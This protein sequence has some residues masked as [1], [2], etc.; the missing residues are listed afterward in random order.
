MVRC[1][2][3]G[4]TIN[5]PWD[6]C[7]LCG[8]DPEG[9]KPPGWQP[10]LRA[11]AQGGSGALPA[12]LPPGSATPGRG[13]LSTSG[14][15]PGGQP[16]RPVGAQGFGPVGYPPPAFGGAP[17]AKRGPTALGVL[18]AVGL[19]FVLIVVVLVGA[20]TLLGK[21]SSSTFSKIDT[22]LPDTPAPRVSTTATTAPTATWS[23]WQ[24]SDKTFKVSFPG[25]PEV[26]P[27]DL[28]PNGPFSAGE[29]AIDASPDGVYFLL[30]FDLYPSYYFSDSS[31]AL[32]ATVDD[33]VKVMTFT[34]TKREP[35]HFAGM[36]SLEFTGTDIKTGEAIGVHGIALISGKRTY[37][38]AAGTVPGAPLAD[39]DTFIGSFH[40]NG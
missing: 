34:F 8:F 33:L 9:L 7:Q 28:S 29:K 6:W 1:P 12:F 23:E 26:I 14:P 15:V 37:L 38:F 10:P 2:R 30:Y 36:P 35:G 18:G 27:V 20:V 4:G 39:F 25:V 11:A 40:I 5:P 19:A 21:S 17:P 22:A 32:N 3:C 24:P 13:G 16:P 31:V